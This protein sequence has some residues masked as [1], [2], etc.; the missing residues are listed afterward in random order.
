[1]HVKASNSEFFV[2][3]VVTAWAL[4]YSLQTWNLLSLRF[5]SNADDI[6]MG[7]SAIVNFDARSCL[8]EIVDVI[9][10]SIKSPVLKVP[11]SPDLIGV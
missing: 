4:K 9:C 7:N 8:S 1:M 2:D 11:S 5:T 10:N 3:L 6:C